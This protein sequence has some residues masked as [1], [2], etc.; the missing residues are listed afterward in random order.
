M[1]SDFED[2]QLLDEDVR[3]EKMQ[4]YAKRPIPRIFHIF[5]MISIL[6]NAFLGFWYMNHESYPKDLRTS[7]AGLVY[8]TPATV[9]RGTAWEDSD[10]PWETLQY[11]VGEVSLDHEYA[12]SMGLPR[13]Q[14]FPWDPSKGIYLTNG[15]HALHC[16]KRIRKT[17]VE[18][19]RGE[20][21]SFP[22]EHSLHCLDALR[23][24]ILCAADD[25][26]LYSSFEHPGKVGWGQGRMCRS[27]DALEKWAIEH[28][29][30]WRDINP[31]DDI[32]TLLR[33]RYCPPGSPYLERIHAI[34][35]DFETG[36]N[37]SAYN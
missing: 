21:I 27:W 6:A 30:C 1:K 17:L 33:Y 11:Y 4:V 36:D 14:D 37:A 26:P 13:A 24:D 7:F 19:V 20:P 29:A 28:S 16:V 32:D 2:H 15:H 35:G 8:D 3:V 23:Q 22:L 18:A 10:D 5:F 9:M 31:E 25:T 12:A 34:F